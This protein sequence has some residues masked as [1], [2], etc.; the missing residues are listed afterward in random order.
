MFILLL[1]LI[2]L[3]YIFIPKN[4]SK[5][6]G[7]HEVYAN[8]ILG[9]AD[10][11]IDVIVVGNSEAY[12]SIIPME[13]WRDYGFTSYVC[14]TSGQTLS[15]SMKFVYT[16]TRKQ[17]PKIVILEADNICKKASLKDPIE[18]VARYI[19][20]ITEYHDRWKNLNINDFCTLPDYTWTDDMKGY[21]YSLDV[22]EAN[23]NGYMEYTD[24]KGK[25]P[26][27]NKLYLKVLNEFCKAN[28]IKL[29]VVSTPSTKNWNYKN[30]NSIK[31]LTEEEDIEFLDFNYRW[32]E[33]KIN[34]R[35]E[36]SDAGDHLNYYGALKVTRYLGKYLYD[37]GMLEDHREDEMYE[38]WNESFERYKGIVSKK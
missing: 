24:K 4:N 32:K 11:T 35:T 12:S 21:R 6:F 37:K 7:I 36:T 13:L 25:I 14:S 31:N 22:C 33:L 17:S 15:E 20:P 16:A 19:L 1:I 8:G 26:R 34:W 38:K 29:I 3:S 23:D 10:N 18:K 30:H 9:E 28:D 27:E 5:E 2:I